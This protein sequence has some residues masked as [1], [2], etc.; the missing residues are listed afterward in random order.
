MPSG[1]LKDAAQEHLCCIPCLEGLHASQPRPEAHAQALHS[2]LAAQQPELSLSHLAKQC[3]SHEGPPLHDRS[4]HCTVEIRVRTIVPALMTA[5]SCTLQTCQYKQ[6]LAAKLS[7][8]CLSRAL[9][10]QHIV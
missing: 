3:P 2:V 4:Q 6:H 10:L 9:W 5:F 8:V 7:A 1:S